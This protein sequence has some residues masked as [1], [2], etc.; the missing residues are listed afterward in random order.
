MI[1]K[2]L[3]LTFILLS[4]VASTT[5]ANAQVV[6][7]RNTG[8]PNAAYPTTVGSPTIGQSFGILAPPS[9]VRGGR[10]FLVFG[11]GGANLTL[12]VPPACTR[13]CKLESTPTIVLMRSSLRVSIP[14]DRSL[15]GLNICAQ[16]GSLD[17]QRGGPRI[18]L[19][20]A[21]SITIQ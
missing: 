18:S 12:P 10:P 16:S 2:F 6:K 17:P 20:G 14:R 3:S 13:G 15:I 9:R 21:L 4:A 7:I 8:C 11:R 19:H 1:H 5:D